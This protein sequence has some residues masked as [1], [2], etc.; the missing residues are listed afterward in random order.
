MILPGLM[1]SAYVSKLYTL[2][3]FFTSTFYSHLN[4]MA[5]R[6]SV[7]QHN[8]AKDTANEIFSIFGPLMSLKANHDDYLWTKNPCFKVHYLKYRCLMRHQKKIEL[9]ELQVGCLQCAI[10]QRCQSNQ[11]REN[12]PFYLSFETHSS[13]AVQKVCPFKFVTSTQ[14]VQNSR[15]DR[16]ELNLVWLF[17]PN[18]DYKNV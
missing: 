17:C 2:V 7:D 12:S 9:Y 10:C 16:N 15:N 6:I 8:T 1:L 5:C 3:W 4:I 18:T 13:L 11:F 14:S